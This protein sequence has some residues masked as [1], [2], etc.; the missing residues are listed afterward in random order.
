MFLSHSYILRG[1]QSTSDNAVILF[2]HFVWWLFQPNA[3]FLFLLSYSLGFSVQNMPLWALKRRGDVFFP[4]LKVFCPRT[5]SYP[6]ITNQ[7][8]LCWALPCY[9]NSASVLSSLS[10]AQAASDAGFCQ[11]LLPWIAGLFSNT[12]TGFE[13]GWSDAMRQTACALHSLAWERRISCRYSH[14]HNLYHVLA[15]NFL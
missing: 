14:R 10:L 3:V 12:L 11:I 9:V 1:I 8:C 7:S 15:A 6:G 5:I 13:R 4:W 2:G